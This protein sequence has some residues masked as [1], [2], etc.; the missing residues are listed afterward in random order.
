MALSPG[1]T[2]AW[3]LV[4]V[5]G[6]VLM[7]VLWF[8]P[9]GP[10]GKG[11]EAGVQTAQLVARAT[12][13]VWERA[14]SWRTPIRCAK[15]PDLVP[16]TLAVGKRR[17]ERTKQGLVGGRPDRGVR[18]G[19]VADSRGASGRTLALAVG[20]RRAFAQA[21]VDMV[22]AAGGLGETRDEIE[23]VLRALAG[24]ETWVVVALPG[25][26]EPVL[27][28]HDAVVQLASEGLPVIDGTRVGMLVVDGVAFGVLPGAP[29]DATGRG[30]GLVAGVDGCGRTR[31]DARSVAARLKE[32]DGPRVIL[33]H[34][35]PRQR[36]LAGSD[37]AVE[38]AHVG[39]LLVTEA[40]R[41]TGAVLV[42]HGLLDEGAGFATRD[43]WSDS[44]EALG[45]RQWGQHVAVAAGSVEAAPHPSR[46]TASG[47]APAVV[48]IAEVEGKR[49]RA[50]WIDP[51]AFAR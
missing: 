14:P 48:A 23:A 13:I 24:E 49:A 43:A 9:K 26:R 47:L 30:Y 51:A 6:V 45:V 33:S 41:D 15:E 8:W 42:V 29:L 46:R 1:K 17:F 34:A 25:D 50:W 28:F 3:A 22:V 18:L 4:L 31:Q 19:I 21:G 5:M 20:A 27:A 32:H 35:P 10:G 38:G 40:A 2:A 16:G 44:A 36:G 12:K 11:I 37:L 7:A 39:D